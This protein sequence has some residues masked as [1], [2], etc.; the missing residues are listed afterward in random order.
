MVLTHVPDS[1]QKDVLRAL[2]R[3]EM[4]AVRN[5]DSGTAATLGL[6]GF[7]K[8]TRSDP[9]GALLDYVAAFAASSNTEKIRWLGHMKCLVGED[10]AA[11]DAALDAHIHQWSRKADAAFAQ[12]ANSPVST[13]GKPSTLAELSDTRP[14]ALLTF[15]VEKI[16]SRI[17][18]APEEDAAASDSRSPCHM[19]H[20][21]FSPAERLQQ[22]GACKL[23]LGDPAGA[24]EEL[25]AAWQQGLETKATYHYRAAARLALG[26]Q[27]WFGGMD[28]SEHSTFYH[29]L[30][31]S[32]ETKEVIFGE[33]FQW[34][35]N[36]REANYKRD[37]VG[38]SY[39]SKHQMCKHLLLPHKPTL[40]AT[41]TVSVAVL[42][43]DSS[44]KG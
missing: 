30:D 28:D 42:C 12:A 25:D 5:D 38:T 24:L 41:S 10:G 33:K 13:L 4:R 6:S 26:T 15:F 2:L 23:H 19:A 20:V 32:V 18:F 17:L 9:V 11:K 35:E 36:R 43:T 39:M 34:K 44:M 7:A 40:S 8:S 37:I 21:A 29:P 27:E 14:K 22:L 31:T 1:V 3:H 16:Q